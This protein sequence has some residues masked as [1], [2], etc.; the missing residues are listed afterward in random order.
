[1][2]FFSH[3]KENKG[4][5]VGRKLLKSH[6]N[7][8]Y[9]KS[10]S[11]FN[12]FIDLDIDKKKA[13]Q[14]IRDIAFFHDLGKYTTYF[15]DYLLERK[16]VDYNLKKHSRVGAFALLNKYEQ[17]P[18]LATFLYFIVMNH[19]SNLGD[20]MQIDIK[21]NKNFTPKFKMLFDKQKTKLLSYL[22][23]L[24]TEI[25]E[26]QLNKLIQ[27]PE[28]RNFGKALIKQIKNTPNVRNYFTVNYLFSLLIEADKLDASCTLQYQRKK[29][30]DL[31]VEKFIGKTD[32]SELPSID[33]IQPFEQNK[34]RN[35]VRASV[36]ENLK[37]P[38]ILKKGIFTLTAP[39]GIGK[40]L[41]S[42][43]FALRLKKK[44]RDN[45]NYEAQIIYGLP[46][47]NIIE[48]GLKVYSNEVFKNEV[49]NNEINI[50][51]H[52]QYADIF[53]NK[54][55]QQSYHQELMAL[56]T[57]Q[58]DIVITSFV[59][60]FETLISNRNKLLL[61]FNHFAGAIVI[62]DEVQ[63]LRLKQLP[64]LGA[65]LYLLS[66]FLHTRLILMTATKP[67][68]FELAN[69]EI[70]KY[71][72]EEV[73]PVELL[74]EYKA[75]FK[76][77]NRTKI[78]PLIK[79][80]IVTAEEFYSIFQEKRSA[81]Q[82]CLVVC[83]TVQRSIDIFNELKNNEISPI[84]YLSTNIVPAVR[85]YIIDRIKLDLKYRKNPILV[86]TQ[87]V[88]AGVDLDFDMGFRDLAPI[89]SIVQ[90]AGR[91]NRE[92][93]KNRVSSPLYIIEFEREYENQSNKSECQMVY[94]KL[95][96]T[97]ASKVLQD[98]PEIQEKDYFELIDNYFKEI[99]DKNAF[100]ES[101]QFFKSIKTLHYDGKENEFPISKF[102]I[103][104]KADWAISVFVELNN[105][106]FKARIA[107]N[108]LQ[109]KEIDKENFDKTFKKIFNLYIIAVPEKFT[110]HLENINEF[111]ENL[112]LIRNKSIEKYYNNDT[113]LIREGVTDNKVVML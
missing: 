51:A 13:K 38:D 76:K 109:N 23:Q 94:D 3:A 98:K 87:V 68:I 21:Q 95:T 83:N 108:K 69:Q 70:L 17:E 80:P 77:F 22:T 79:S 12:E 46:F 45:E 105:E 41:T 42:L 43:D 37:Q 102:K 40:T 54:K 110:N 28:T 57:W 25:D 78:V 88:E 27:I 62:L 91:I 112:K 72:N 53:G 66:K 5:K 44:I 52:Y 106:A 8:V 4:V 111:T 99:S 55:Q 16:K 26:K 86:S 96:Y 9:Q 18:L 47:I 93:S 33:K 58:A 75:V 74:K 30:T 92:N 73:K 50:L 84:Y 67:K 14:V 63:T 39:T 10:F 15:Q 56:N 101:R 71:E 29:I 82:S 34:L 35:F 48:Q 36:L 64:L 81:N 89:D 85:M 107:Y 20:I 6:L 104:E 19:H 90:V 11:A 24:E 113:G 7:G 32:L 1:M 31:A 61:K 2:E 49:K 65:V 60:F 100:Y 59:Q 97:Q 103:I